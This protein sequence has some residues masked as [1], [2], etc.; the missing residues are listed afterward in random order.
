MLLARGAP[1]SLA[2]AKHD[3]TALALAD[4]QVRHR[5]RRRGAVPVL[6]AGRRINGVARAD[7]RHRLALGLHPAAALRDVERLSGGMG[8]PVLRDPA[9]K[10]T[11][12]GPVCL[13]AGQRSQEDRPSEING[14]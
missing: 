10:L 13:G 5:A 8:V 2:P 6:G 4:R 1:R 7:S 3:M 11:S 9:E 14:Q 12:A